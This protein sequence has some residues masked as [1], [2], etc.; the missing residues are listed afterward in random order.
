MWSSYIDKTVPPSRTEWNVHIVL[1]SGVR[2][3]L[4]VFYGNHLAQQ[5]WT[6]HETLD[7]SFKDCKIRSVFRRLIW[8]S[9]HLWKLMYAKCALATNALL[10][11]YVL[12]KRFR[13]WKWKIIFI[14]FLL[15]LSLW[16]FG[17]SRIKM[18]ASSILK[19]VDNY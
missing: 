15:E 11:S 8:R 1:Q 13:D 3:L 19:I 18:S 14:F 4:E 17:D 2:T 10:S 7:W 5:L 9:Y 6:A 16:K 12:W